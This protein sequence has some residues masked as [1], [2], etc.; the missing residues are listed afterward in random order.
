[1]KLKDG[2]MTRETLIENKII[3]EYILEKSS[4][5]IEKKEKYNNEEI[6]YLIVFNEILNEGTLG[7]KESLEIIEKI[8]QIYKELREEETLIIRKKENTIFYYLSGRKE[9]I[10]KDNSELLIKIN[11]NGIKQKIIQLIN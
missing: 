8:K 4:K 9:E 3:S 6:L 11:L 5:L 1:G 7:I 2:Y 10:L